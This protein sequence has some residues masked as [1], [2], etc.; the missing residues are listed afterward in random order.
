MTIIY[1]MRDRSARF[2]MALKP[3]AE[4]VCRYR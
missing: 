1:F 3:A 2:L 4:T